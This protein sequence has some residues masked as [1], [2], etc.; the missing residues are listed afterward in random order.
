MN[1]RR[2]L[3]VLLDFLPT[4]SFHVRD[5]D[6]FVSFFPMMLMLKRISE[7]GHP[8]L[9]PGFSGKASSFL[10]LSIMLD[11]YCLCYLLLSLGNSLLF[12]PSLLR[13]FIMNA[14]WILGVQ[15]VSN[16]SESFVRII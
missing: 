11:V 8:C 3:P 16:L 2:F 13:V 15:W 12:I 5:K 10:S 7:R 14:C 1:F 9:V 4:P 6:R